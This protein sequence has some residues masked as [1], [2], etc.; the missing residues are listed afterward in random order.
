[1]IY[2]FALSPELVATWHDRREYLFFD[3]KFGLKTGRIVSQYPKKWR[4]LV[5]EA[6]DR[7]PHAQDQSARK[8]LETLLN[9]LRQNSITRSN[10]F[11]ELKNW[12]EK[13]E[14]EHR[15]RPFYGILA[16]ENPG[17]HNQVILASAL[18]ENGNDRWSIPDAPPIPRN[19]EDMSAAIAPILRVCK[20]I[21]FIDPYF[22][23][24]QQRFR[25]PMEQFLRVVWE[26]RSDN[27]VPKV[28]IHTG[29]D[30][31]FDAHETGKDR[32]SEEEKRVV[33]D[34]EQCFAKNLPAII[35]K[36]K[37]VTVVLWKGREQGQKLHN[38]YLLT[39]ACGV[40][41]GT[42]LDQNNEESS[43]ATDD[44]H[45]LDGAKLSAHWNEYSEESAAFDLV[46]KSTIEGRKG[47]SV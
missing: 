4:N 19:A 8:R 41:F 18:I 21:V 14:A 28:E 2:E 45:L 5:W 34:V 7:S 16:N 1:M 27:D 12:L 42:G 9:Y 36:G 26:N 22:A 38:R 3:E 10:T 40:G 44:L 47:E 29:I 46:F 24:N 35:P 6:F 30:R 15:E 31:Y 23:P 11:P 43:Y 37:T 33:R 32:S 17:A 25:V 13:A 20:R 39:E